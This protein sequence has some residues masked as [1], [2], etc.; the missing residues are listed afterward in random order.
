VISMFDVQDII[1]PEGRLV[2]RVSEILGSTRSSN[3]RNHRSK[4]R[5]ESES[6]LTKWASA[7]DAARYI[8]AFAKHR[9]LIIDGFASQFTGMLNADRHPE[10]LNDYKIHTFG[11]GLASDIRANILYDYVN[12]YVRV[13]QEVVDFINQTYELSVRSSGND[14][15][16]FTARSVDVDGAGSLLSK[17]YAQARRYAM[18]NSGYYSS[19]V[20]LFNP[21]YVISNGASDSDTLDG[22]AFYMSMSEALAVSRMIWATKSIR[23]TRQQLLEAKNEIIYSLRVSENRVDQERKKQSRTNFAQY[24]G[25]MKS[26]AEM[27]AKG[28]EILASFSTIPLLPAGTPSSRTWGI[29]VEVVQDS[30]V[31]GKP[32][33]WKKHSDGS[34][35]GIGDGDSG[36]C[37]CGCDECDEYDHCGYDDCQY[38]NGDN[39]AEYVSPIL[40][41]FN[42]LGLRALC[43]DLDG[44]EVNSTPGIHIHVGADGLTPADIARLLAMYSAASPFIWPVMERETRNYCRDVTTDNIAYWMGKAREWRTKP[45]AR[46]EQQN[47]DRVLTAVNGQ[48]DDRYRDINLQALHAHGT[49]EFRAMGPIYNYDRLVRWAW[50][51][52]EMMNVSKLDIPQSTWTNIRSMADLVRLLRQ[53][54]S[55]Q[56]PDNVTKLYELGDDLSVEGVAEANN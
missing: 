47:W 3:L 32:L 21:S 44:S 56:L 41:A 20:Y 53:F 25:E 23:P 1:V 31:S 37:D 49:I 4:F 8:L 17:A 5:I 33:G 42:S 15:S 12:G 7:E 11:G 27:F 40:R 46:S 38:D 29:E 54:G 43:N 24:W 30:L 36:Y 52:R 22:D 45:E 9:Q 50:M 13:P 16:C 39:T 14:Y 35:T 26:R 18:I 10:S 19:Q 51:V 48:P 2:Y 55:E 6:D 34:L 28:D